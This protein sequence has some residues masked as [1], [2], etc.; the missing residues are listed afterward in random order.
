MRKAPSAV[1]TMRCLPSPPPPSS[2][3]KGEA[4]REEEEEEAAQVSPQ[5]TSCLKSAEAHVGSQALLLKAQEEEEDDT[6][7]KT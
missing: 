5:R 1:P 2:C 7:F 6:W 3:E 4:G